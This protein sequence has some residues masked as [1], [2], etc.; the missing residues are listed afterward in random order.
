MGLTII[1]ES[2]HVR[3]YWRYQIGYTSTTSALAFPSP[4]SYLRIRLPRVS[5]LSRSIAIILCLLDAH[6]ILSPL[7]YHVRPDSSPLKLLAIPDFD[8][9]SYCDAT[10]FCPGVSCLVSPRRLLAYFASIRH[11]CLHG[12]PF[13]RFLSLTTLLSLIR[14]PFLVDTFF[15]PP[16]A[17]LGLF[18]SSLY[19]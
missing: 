5:R 1:S 9:S 19:V 17:L 18:I 16:F 11:D 8:L 6:V 3:G 13:R 15:Y 14:S 2:I 7:S 4:S 10:P 12:L